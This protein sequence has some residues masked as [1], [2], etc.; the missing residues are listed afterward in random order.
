MDVLF[1]YGADNG[2]PV[3]RQQKR[4]IIN[5]MRGDGFGC[6]ALRLKY[7]T[8]SNRDKVA[9]GFVPNWVYWLMSPKQRGQYKSRKRD[10]FC[11]SNE[12]IDFVPQPAIGRMV[13]SDSTVRSKVEQLIP[14]GK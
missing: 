14:N 9:N 5:Q 3:D 7:S 8:S 4:R 2:D 11:K 1:P 12:I 13:E 6:I 10:L